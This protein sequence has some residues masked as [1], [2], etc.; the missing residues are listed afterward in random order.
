[1]ALRPTTLDCSAKSSY[2]ALLTIIMLNISSYNCRSS[3]RNTGGIKMLCDSS[4]IVFLQEHWLFASDLP[5]LNNVHEDF[6]S[7][8]V[9]AMD[10]TAGLT[11]GRPY[12]GVAVLWR[13]GL[14]ARVRPLSYDDSRI[15][16]LMCDLGGTQILFL[17]AYLPYESPQNFDEF[18]FYLA[19]VKEIIDEFPS[20]NVCVLGDLNA[21][22]IKGTSFGIELDNFCKDNRLVIADIL[23]LPKDSVTHLN[24]GH[25]SESWLDH[26]VCT[27]AFHSLLTTMG[28]RYDIMSSDHFPIFASIATDS[29]PSP[30]QPNKSC[31]EDRDRWLVDWSSVSQT[32]L[33]SFAD[34]VDEQL[35]R[36]HVPIDAL[37]CRDSACTQH[38]LAISTYYS[39]IINC[40]NSSSRTIGRKHIYRQKAVPGWTEYV[41]DKHALVG[42]VYSLWALVGK[43]RVG[44]IYDQL[45]LAKTRFK[46]ALRFCV[47]N[48]KALRAK[49]LADKL[50]NKPC[51]FAKFWK[52]VKK[53]NSEPPLSPTVDGVSGMEE[54][55][56]MWK[57]HFSGILNSVPNEALKE[58]VLTEVE[59]NASDF[60][61][62]SVDDVRNGLLSLSLGKCGHD[63]LSVEHF[64]HSGVSCATHLSLCLTMMV[65]H[66][67]MPAELTKVVLVPIL[68]DKTGKISDKDNYRPIAIAS[69]ISKLLEEIILSRS[70]H[71]LHTTDHQFGFKSHNSTDMAIY[72]LK[73]IT[74]HYQRNNSS[75]FICF[76]DARKAFDR[77]NHWK[78]FDKLLKRGMNARWV[79]LLISW[80]RTQQFHVRWG[81]HVTDGFAVSNGVRQGGILSPYLYN[82]YTDD[83]SVV[84]D[85]SGVGC[86]YQGSV[87]HLAYADD[88]VLL[89][90]TAFGLQSLLNICETYAYEHDIIYNTKK[91]VCMVMR[92]K[93]Y[94]HAVLPN[95]A[96]SGGV[97]SYVD[98]YKYLGYVLTSSSSAVDNEEIRHQYRQMCCRANSL[99]RK[100]AMCE[101]NVKKMLYNAY[102]ASVYCI[103]LWHS[104]HVSVINKFKVCHNNA[105]RM[106][107][108]YDKFCSASAM[109]VDER[110]DNL[111]VMYR[112]AAWGFSCRLRSSDNRIMSTLYNSD[113]ACTSSI[114]RA[115]NKALY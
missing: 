45:Q 3:K 86:H 65:R 6:I 14:A 46:Y 104:F 108:G 87:N 39:D 112:K 57:D 99:I 53:L 109:F 106:F 89:S 37:H 95:L 88:M 61:N 63:G 32:D 33:A 71:C 18:V 80:Y 115:W 85:A 70:K 83:L 23:Q 17:G 82:V 35:S 47:R 90:P 42:D 29:C 59:E 102:C 12:G 92:S 54:I 4:D 78:L 26:I 7:F 5:T 111:D 24:D 43:P 28:I 66:S 15:I 55:G 62:I 27:Q 72:A 41:Q 31:P 107:F 96:L 68:K 105:T 22:V 50:M 40:L 114:R 58:A 93:R 94:K 98:Q 97:L 56:T 60:V 73:E 77:V 110:V 81:N 76:L 48:E 30:V 10:P 67:Y 52:E 74:D 8:G 11:V 16:G 9:S 2:Y 64:L 79:K 51:N 38:L 19:K 113:L 13:K 69:V 101:K 75:V 1:M 84:L 103:H 44:Y 20:P 25:G 100:F 34:M 36:L 49:S 21:D 91:S